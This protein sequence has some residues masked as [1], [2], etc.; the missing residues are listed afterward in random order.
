MVDPSVQ[1]ANEL[2]A[3]GQTR[4]ASEMAKGLLKSLETPNTRQIYAR[5]YAAR[6]RALAL[7]GLFR[8]ARSLGESVVE[9]H[10]FAAATVN[11]ALEDL[12]LINNKFEVPLRGLVSGKEEDKPRFL[13]FLSANLADP[14]WVSD[15]EFLPA[16]HPLKTEAKAV[17]T[18]FEAVTSGSVDPDVL[19]PL[20]T[21][22]RSSIFAPWK[23]AIRA[24]ASASQNDFESAKKNASLIPETS[25][26]HHIVPVIQH[27]A[28]VKAPKLS[29][30]GEQLFK[31]LAS[32]RETFSTLMRTLDEVLHRR[33]MDKYALARV[34]QA[35]E[36]A[37]PSIPGAVR[38]IV[39][40]TVIQFLAN[41]DIDQE[42]LSEVLSS[43]KDRAEVLRLAALSFEREDA[44]YAASLWERYL[45]LCHSK[46]VFR[47]KSLETA[48]V[49]L[50]ICDALPPE[51]DILEETKCDSF[52]DFN[53]AIKRRQIPEVFD[54]EFLLEKALHCHPMPVLFSK[55]HT[56]FLQRGDGA[57][58]QP[59]CERWRQAFPHE[60]EPWI[61]L[62]EAALMA[63]QPERARNLCLE[64][65][66]AN[67][68]DPR[69]RELYFSVLL[70]SLEDGTREMSS[71]CESRLSAVLREP[72]AASGSGRLYVMALE[73]VLA[74]KREGD[75]SNR[76]AELL[77]QLQKETGNEATV[78]ILLHTA[79]AI[80]GL[81]TRPR[82]ERKGDI[83]EGLKAAK[84]VLKALER[85][86]QT[87]DEVLV[88]L[89][90][91]F[92]KRSTIQLL[93]F[94]RGDDREPPFTYQ[95]EKL[96]VLHGFKRRNEFLSLFLNA[97]LAQT[98]GGDASIQ[99]IKS[100]LELAS[101][102]RALFNR[103][104]GDFAPESG[105]LDYLD[106]I[107]DVAS[108][109]L[110]LRVK[111]VPS[112]KDI[113]R[114]LEREIITLE[115]SL[116]GRIL[117]PEKRALAKPASKKSAPRKKAPAKKAPKK[118]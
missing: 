43:S 81:K 75:N 74:Y 67:P 88:W 22:P 19:R 114:I 11:Q 66:E 24:I 32:S 100:S 59:L 51:D 77:E 113:D 50:H 96:A 105:M 115:L 49:L 57:K 47:E 34:F 106:E 93:E 73:W 98:L 6:I 40:S 76:A 90:Q 71:D 48:L 109:G 95:L 16:D 15:S 29:H 41:H 69:L 78:L 101:A 80:C 86:M 23:L 21:I 53:R 7:E 79:A 87:P 44:F 35:I 2:L 107:C 38:S 46:Q 117:A 20:D 45:D 62:V 14:R 58:L 94:L 33:T 118:P 9:R 3:A 12:K 36:S 39:L 4:E 1:T 70:R 65:I 97:R 68:I 5:A 84:K 91:E 116:F 52:E 55:L 104:P 17:W 18:A 92:I 37:L 72:L 27:L 30:G 54:R 28:G 83:I 10:P 103:L 111:A 60:A 99:K 61:H 31:G 82:F 89:D 56:L 85:V 13:A 108:M 110:G 42:V 63:S 64:A 102:A 25:R 112:R 26:V 8:D